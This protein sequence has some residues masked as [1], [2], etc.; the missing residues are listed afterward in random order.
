M[1]K[2]TRLRTVTFKIP[3]NLL[4]RLDIAANKL[5]MS[6]S[7]VIREAI[8]AYLNNLPQG[9]GIMKVQRVMLG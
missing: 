5:G 2:V 9:C 1:V 7:E 4:E 6:R 8:L 3:E